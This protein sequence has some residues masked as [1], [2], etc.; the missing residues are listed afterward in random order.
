M[1]K[2]VY[3]RAFHDLELLRLCSSLCDWTTALISRWDESSILL[4]LLLL[5]QY[6]TKYCKL[7]QSTL[8]TGEIPWGMNITD[9][10][11]LSN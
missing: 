2:G 10:L 1:S 6:N 11:S 8:E 5:R 3:V 4:L 9:Y 7:W